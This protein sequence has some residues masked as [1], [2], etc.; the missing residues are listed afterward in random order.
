MKEK[1]NKRRDCRGKEAEE[2]NGAPVFRPTVSHDPFFLPCWSLNPA[3]TF[4]LE[5]YTTRPTLAL[6]IRDI[7]GT[8]AELSAQFLFS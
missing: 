3:L 6:L 5:S 8:L 7:S 1:R 4:S 2:R